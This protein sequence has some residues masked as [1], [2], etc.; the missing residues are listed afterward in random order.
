M[1]LTGKIWLFVQP[2]EKFNT[3]SGTISHKNEDNS[4]TRKTIELS[5]IKELDEKL[6]NLDPKFA[7][8]VEILKSFLDVRK[9]ND[10]NGKEQRVLLIKIQEAKFLNKKEIVK[11]EKEVANDL[12]F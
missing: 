3:Y 8:E 7:Y 9:Y 1:N 6:R 2:H 11:T 4:Y 5:F 12:P 10:K